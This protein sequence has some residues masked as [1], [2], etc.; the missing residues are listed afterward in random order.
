VFLRPAHHLALR[1]RRRQ[2]RADTQQSVQPPRRSRA[3]PLARRNNQSNKCATDTPLPANSPRL[4]NVVGSDPEPSQPVPRRRAE[5]HGSRSAGRHARRHLDARG[6]GDV[7]PRA[8]GADARTDPWPVPSWPVPSWPVPSLPVP[9][10]GAV[11]VE[12]DWPA[13]SWPV[14][15]WPVPH[16]GAV[17][18]VEVDWPAPSW[19]DPVWP[20]CARY[21]RRWD[22]TRHTPRA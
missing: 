9:R 8:G 10:G 16:G 7:S 19:P 5:L 17:G 18:G 2:L 22:G 20:V 11:G 13:P 12:V 15:S 14:R 1:V 21:D 4:R 6:T 3:G